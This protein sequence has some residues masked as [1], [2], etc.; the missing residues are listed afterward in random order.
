MPKLRAASVDHAH[1]AINRVVIIMRG[2]LFPEHFTVQE[3][4]NER[5]GRVTIDAHER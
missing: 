3:P 1:D 4:L 2:E 5:V